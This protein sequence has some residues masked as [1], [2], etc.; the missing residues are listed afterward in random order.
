MIER[1]LKI[2]GLDTKNKRAKL[3]DC[4]E[5]KILNKDRNGKPREQKWNY[6]SAVGCLS[7]IQAMIR[8]DITMT[9]QQGAIFWNDP[10]QEHK[11]D[12]KVY[13]GIY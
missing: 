7:N 4:P 10:L 9:A 8:L 12:V 5:N 3:H 2:V 11:E 13:A 1:V 6:I